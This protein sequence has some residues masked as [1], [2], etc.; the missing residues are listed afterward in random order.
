MRLRRRSLFSFLTAWVA[1]LPAAA[2]ADEDADP[3]SYTGE[4]SAYEDEAIQNAVRTLGSP[5]EPS[6]EGK[7][8]E[9]IEII[10]LDPVETRDPTPSWLNA[11]H[12]TT[13]HGVVERDLLVHVGDRYQKVVVD[14]SARNLRLHPQLSV[15]LCVAL[16]G[17]SED[18][19]WLVV[20]TKDV[21]SLMP[22]FDLQIESGGYDYIL[23][24][25]KE[26]NLLGTHEIVLGRLNLTPKAYSIGSAFQE[27]RLSGTWISVLADANLIIN[28][29]SGTPEGSFGTLEV[30]KPLSSSKDPWSWFMDAA[31]RSEVTRRYSNGDVY[32][33]ALDR[34]TVADEH[35]TQRALLE[36]AL[37]RSFGWKQKND[38]TVGFTMARDQYRVDPTVQA[39]IASG[40][41]PR[42]PTSDK[43]VGP[44]LE[45]HLYTSDFLRTLDYDTLGLQEDYRLGYDVVLR[46][47]PILRAFGSTRNV[48]GFYAAGQ[49]TLP[50]ATGLI[51]G[52]TESRAE[53]DV[54]AHAAEVSC[55]S[56]CGISDGSMAARLTLV[57]PLTVAGRL[58]FG[59][60][61][62][63]R[64]R[65]YLNATSFLGSDSTLRGYPAA[66][67][68]GDD[69]VS[70]S[71][72]FR[73]RPIE[74]WSMQW[75]LAGFYDVG[76]A[77]DRFSEIGAQGGLRS[78]VGAG[79]RMVWPELERAVF[80][81]DFGFPLNRTPLPGKDQ[82]VD[83]W[84]FSF[85]F[86]QA[87][88]TDAIAGTS[89][90]DG[91]AV[92]E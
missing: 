63:N 44:A 32:A 83:P 48:F 90:P 3:S 75:A 12:S 27:P 64:Y 92:F 56:A 81:L 46:A 51:R 47:Y 79:I 13:R 26:M 62:L 22:D 19:V 33:V 70:A 15:V 34:N 23:L 57:S 88:G 85:S 20:I 6:P 74:A 49:Y 10:T 8:V 4:Y 91:N 73:T 2:A 17:T 71:V 67:L 24:E 37:T 55:A 76:E 89:P 42:V 11:L 38:V 84:T 54:G 59:G 41:L 82:P 9:R 53:W 1:L 43:R 50:L 69:E 36:G 61:V 21:W 7:I 31:W 60:H 25:P 80:R 77:F 87:F 72:E 86:G 40:L 16:R 68:S 65:N 29:T 78:D 5:I 28:K 14:E 66:S 30:I 39:A 52:A 35:H 58:L 18:Q 45:L